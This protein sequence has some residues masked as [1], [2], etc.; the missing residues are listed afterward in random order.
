MNDGTMRTSS[1]DREGQTDV[2][3]YSKSTGSKDLDGAL[4]H[5]KD[6]LKD[7]GKVDWGK[8]FQGTTVYYPH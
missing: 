1:E 5:A 2:Q 6:V 4:D 8:A 3:G 7:F